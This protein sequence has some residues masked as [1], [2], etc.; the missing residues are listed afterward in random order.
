MSMRYEVLERGYC[1][2]YAAALRDGIVLWEGDSAEEAERVARRY[3]DD[4]LAAVV[5][6]RFTGE[7]WDDLHE[8][9]TVG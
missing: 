3:T 1:H 9:V 2:S 8:R 6:D 4:S 7:M 5:H